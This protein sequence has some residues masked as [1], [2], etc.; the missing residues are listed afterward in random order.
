MEK[1]VPVG[2][3]DDNVRYLAVSA[4]K[5]DMEMFAF[6]G[7][8]KAYGKNAFAGV[9][10]TDGGACPRAEQFKDV[11]DDDMAELR[12]VE[13]KRAAEKGG[14]AALW[15]FEKTSAEIKAR[16]RDIVEQLAA[17]MRRYP[18]LDVLYLHNPFDRH[19][20][21]VAACLVALDA[22]NLL[23]DDEKPRKIYG[24]EV[25][26]DLDWVADEDKVVFDVSGYETLASDLMSVFVT[27]NAV[28]RYDI[29]AL[30]R[31][32]A[33]ATFCQSHEGDKAQ[34]LI[35]ALDMTEIAHGTDV[36][37]FAGRIFDDFKNSLHVKVRD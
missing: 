31:R 36:E 16:S 20:T 22:V 21:H 34:S 37:A 29:A 26:R 33:N 25:W 35:Y 12:T 30:A 1:F 17:I 19:P 23:N 27:Q 3:N 6:D 18:R 10:L 7:I 14:Y 15:L 28:K 13:Q 4:H 11:S 24:C 2:A 8:V 5:D 32:R 9:V